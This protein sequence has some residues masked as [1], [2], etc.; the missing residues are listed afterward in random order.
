MRVQGLVCDI[1]LPQ[2]RNRI[3]GETVPEGS[4]S[5]RKVESIHLGE[6]RDTP[7]PISCRRWKYQA[8]DSRA[9]GRER[10]FKRHTSAQI[11]RRT[12]MPKGRRFD[13]H[14]AWSFA[15]FVSR[16]LPWGCLEQSGFM[17]DPNRAATWPVLGC[18][19]SGLYDKSP[20]LAKSE[21]IP[22]PQ[23]RNAVHKR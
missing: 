19:S 21:V 13:R 3:F 7:A 16:L 4:H 14:W 23:G 8:G 18:A 9:K 15:L 11:R 5:S 17:R 2:N 1:S 12:L 22:T 10:S 6:N 20:G